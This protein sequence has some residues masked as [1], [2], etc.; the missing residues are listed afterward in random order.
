[1][2]A[3]D[4]CR[5]VPLA[6]GEAC[7]YCG[8]VPSPFA[9][10]DAGPRP[11]LSSLVLQPIPH[12]APTAHVTGVVTMSLS[13]PPSAEVSPTGQPVVPGWFPAVATALVSAAYALQQVVPPHTVGYQ[14]AG[15]VIAAGAVFGILSPGLRKK[16]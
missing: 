3:C 2:S 12:P 4:F 15:F 8:H 9:V 7:G 16:Q 11:A 1:M 5:R 13:P 6:I 10:E 14:V